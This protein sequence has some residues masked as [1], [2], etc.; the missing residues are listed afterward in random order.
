MSSA[1]TPGRLGYPNLICERE[2]EAARG[3]PAVDGGDQRLAEL[4]QRLADVGVL[5]PAGVPAEAQLRRLRRLAHVVA[6]AEAAA[7]GGQDHRVD[8]LVG[9]DV[10]QGVQHLVVGVPAKGVEPLGP[11]EG[12]RGDVVALLHDQIDVVHEALTMPSP[13]APG[14][15]RRPSGHHGRPF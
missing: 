11:V 7:V 9:V 12:D 8:I 1:P 13:C 15:P 5:A 4:K 14:H 3:A 2:A 6:G 10:G